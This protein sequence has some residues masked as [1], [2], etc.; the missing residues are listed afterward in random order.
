[1]ISPEELLHRYWKHDS[2]REPQ[3]KIIQAVLEQKNVLALL[4]TGSGKSLCFQIPA[5]LKEGVCL[6]ISPLIALMNDQ[7]ESLNKK[8]IKSIAL[9]SKYSFDETII[10]FDN[11]QY[12][13]YKFLYL[14]P[15][16]LQSDLIQEKIKQL[17]VNLIAV[18]EAHCISEWGHDFRPSYLKINTLH[19]LHP[20]VNT[21]ALT[22]TATP[23]VVDDIIE[24]LS[25]ENVSVFKKS[26]YRQNIRYQIKYSE[27]ILNRLKQILSNFNEPIIIYTNTRKSC[28][29]ISK[30][31]NR[32]NFNSGYY[33]G[34]L[35]F[36]EK[37]IAYMNWSNEKTP[38]IVATN[39][40]G[41]GI[42]KTNVRAVIH[43]N[44]PQSIENFVQ[45]T[46]RAGRDGKE[47]FSYLL[48]NNNTITDFKNIIQKSLA[49]P[50]ICKEVYINLNQFYQIAPGEKPDKYFDFILQD[51]CNHF[52]LPVVITYNALTTL[53]IENVIEFSQNINRNSI[54]RI[55]VSNDDLFL[56][57]KRNPNSKK[58]IQ[59]L[60]RNYG[61]IFDQFTNVSEYYIA[62]QLQL[63]KLDVV[64]FL[65]QLHNDN[66]LIYKYFKGIS[67]IKFLVPREDKYAMGII[68]KNISKRNKI[69]L[70]KADLVIEFV[71]NNT[72]CR[73]VQLQ[74][75]FGEKKN[76]NNCRI[77]DVCTTKNSAKTDYNAIANDILNLFNNNQALYS[78]EITNKLFF[79]E[80]NILKTLQFLLEK[81]ALGLTS[82]N[83]Y[84]KL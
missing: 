2:F 35:T 31:L 47:S 34:G 55:K 58:L 81:K 74:H 52:N 14:S 50:D 37:D 4:P 17:N 60:L 22:A 69:K 23:E 57:Q 48:Y 65:D 33:H 49:T 76:V 8:G 44:L 53:Q 46:G 40:F 80:N 11:L 56:Y 9:T 10:A 61:G 62:N 75:Y 20:H 3:L 32:N 36:D 83:K 73:S 39:A 29:N 13:D 15:E 26:F 45:E 7:V 54:I 72:V 27:D 1:M 79:D 63:T 18:D 6:V 78:N 19:K 24:Y 12:G 64:K 21:I 68:T 77:C 51:F 5:L 30:F 66:I 67:Q 42:D 43:I 38:I 25:I 71:E 59:I 70:R 28:I 41:M 16:K 82:Q 84:K